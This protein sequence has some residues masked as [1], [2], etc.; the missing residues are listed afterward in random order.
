MRKK[1]IFLSKTF[2]MSGFDTFVGHCLE[3][4]MGSCFFEE[5][6]IFLGCENA[7]ADVQEL[8]VSSLQLLLSFLGRNFEM[9]INTLRTESDVVFNVVTKRKLKIRSKSRGH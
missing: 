5:D 7:I 1:G 6:V 2:F 8:S 9:Y 3:E 4:N